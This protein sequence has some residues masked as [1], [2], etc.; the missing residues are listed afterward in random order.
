MKLGIVKAGLIAN[1]KPMDGSPQIATMQ[2]GEYVFGELSVAQTDLINFDHYYRANDQRV[3][4]SKPCKV[5]VA[6]M[7]V[8]EGTE[9]GPDPEPPPVDPDGVKR[10]IESHVT[11][12]TNAGAIVTVR[13]IPE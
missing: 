13:L 3:D 6:N 9:P 5:S 12:E 11:Y 2:A 10:I 1:V 4:L 7:T 8:T